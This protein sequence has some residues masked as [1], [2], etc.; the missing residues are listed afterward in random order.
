MNY[1][2]SLKFDKFASV[3][4]VLPGSL[5]KLIKVIERFFPQV[6]QSFRCEDGKVGVLN[7]VILGQRWSSVAI[8]DLH[9]N[10]AS[11]LHAQLTPQIAYKNG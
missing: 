4:V 10:G 5:T 6:P 1:L 7:Q 2:K 8:Q 11:L 3:D 9:K